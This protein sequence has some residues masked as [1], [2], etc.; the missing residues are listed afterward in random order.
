MKPL[1]KFFKTC[2]DSFHLNVNW[3]FHIKLF[4]YGDY[5]YTRQYS[6]WP[7]K[8]NPD[9]IAELFTTDKTVTFYTMGGE[10]VHK[11]FETEEEKEEFL[12]DLYDTIH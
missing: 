11:V 7:K 4:F 8:E 12:D 2:D 5:M 3:F 10:R 9:F 6:D 1:A